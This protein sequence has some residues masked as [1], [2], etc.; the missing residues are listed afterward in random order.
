MGFIPI[1]AVVVLMRFRPL[2]K[3]LFESIRYCLLNLG[4]DTRKIMLTMA[5]AA[6]FLSPAQAAEKKAKTPEQAC[7]AQALA[8][9][10]SEWP[11][12]LRGNFEIILKGNRCL[13]FLQADAVF[14]GKRTAW[15]IDGKN[16]ELLSEFY[17]PTQGV[18]LKTATAASA[19]T[20]AASSRRPSAR[21]ASTWT[22]LT[23]CESRAVWV[24][25]PL[26]RINVSCYAD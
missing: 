9:I 3:Y 16:G 4:E 18:R 19:A 24:L 6:A 26:Y 11:N 23:R 22:K 14:E 2:S 1:T 8:S 21:G 15:L 20:A 25:L 17:G 12:V 7:Q 5:A 10:A 13:V